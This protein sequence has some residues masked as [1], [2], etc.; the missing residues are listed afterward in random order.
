M[1]L[2]NRHLVTTATRFLLSLA[3]ATTILIAKAQTPPSDSKPAEA[4]AATDATAAHPA[5]HDSPHFPEK[6][7]TFYLSTGAEAHSLNDIQTA[8][9]NMLNRARIWAT[10][11]QGTITVGGTPDE[12][13]IARKIIAELDHPKKLYRLTYTVTDSD[14]GKHIGIQHFAMVIAAGEKTELKQ[15]SRV[16]ILT[17]AAGAGPSDRNAS[18]EYLDIGLDINATVEDYGDGIRLNSKLSQSSITDE[19]PGTGVAEDPL[20]RQTTLEGTSIFALGKPLSLGSL[21]VP[22]STRHQEIEVTAELLH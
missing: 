2:N 5:S 18:V 15:G 13:E 1:N 19:K 12:V 14:S 8:I 21:D 6:I 20:I 22:G 4:T 9:R 3:L 10:P 16:P 17:A 7:Q 11:T